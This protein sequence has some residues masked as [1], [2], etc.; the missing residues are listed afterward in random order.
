MYDALLSHRVYKEAWDEERV[1]EEMR[2]L[3]GTKFDPELIE[4]FFSILPNIRTISEKYAGD[5]E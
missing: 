4:I 3:A 5:Q 1:L 2:R